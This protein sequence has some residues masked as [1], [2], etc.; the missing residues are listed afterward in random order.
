MF[1]HPD[2]TLFLARERQ[3]DL[4]R[5]AEEAALRRARFGRWRLRHRR[6]HANPDELALAA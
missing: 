1:T 2:L 6:W 3:A 4:R 5:A